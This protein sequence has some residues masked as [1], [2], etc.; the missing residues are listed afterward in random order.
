VGSSGSIGYTGPTG[1]PG[2]DGTIITNGDLLLHSLSFGSLNPASTDPRKIVI[3]PEGKGIQL[4]RNVVINQNKFFLSENGSQPTHLMASNPSAA[5]PLAMTIDVNDTSGNIMT[6]EDGLAVSLPITNGTTGNFQYLTTEYF[7][8]VT[9]YFTNLVVDNLTASGFEGGHTGPTGPTG[10]MGS[11]GKEGKDG[12]T[13][14]AG[15]DGSGILDG[16]IEASTAVFSDINTGNPNVWINVN[17]T[18]Q[19]DISDGFIKVGGNSKG[20]IDTDGLVVNS[21]TNLYGKVSISGDIIGNTASFDYINTPSI[22]GN[23]GHFTYLSADNMD[24][25]NTQLF[26]D[27]NEELITC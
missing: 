10:P 25:S 4:F 16:K 22:I 26:P 6:V 20:M 27:K 2:K 15:Q 13:G 11:N 24:T 5:S 1:A 14:P 3:N 21:V 12:P 17:T 8:G 18:S 9:G 23:S 7:S 19:T